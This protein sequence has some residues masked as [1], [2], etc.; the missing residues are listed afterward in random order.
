MIERSALAID[1]V[2]LLRFYTSMFHS[3]T[4]GRDIASLSSKLRRRGEIVR[5]CHPRTRILELAAPN[6]GCFSGTR[7]R[8]RTVAESFR[9]KSLSR[10]VRHAY[11]CRV[12]QWPCNFRDLSGQEEERRIYRGKSPATPIPIPYFS[13]SSVSL[14]LS[15]LL[16]RP[17]PATSD[18]ISGRN[19]IALRRADQSA[20]MTST[21]S[22]EMRRFYEVARRFRNHVVTLL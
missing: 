10:Y 7:R 8:R 17:P 11:P 21:T 16:V 3:N 22:Q 14:S 13:P 6:L 19:V 2:F 20:L 9:A 18:N 4:R 12:W 1:L 15:P 5:I